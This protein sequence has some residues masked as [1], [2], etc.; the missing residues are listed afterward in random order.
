[1]VIVGVDCSYTGLG[2]VAVPGDWG[3]D[4]RRV[5]R[6]T[7]QTK[8][9][10]PLVARAGAL[11]RDAC[12]WIEWAAR[13]GGLAVYIEGGLSRGGKGDSVRTQSRLIGV[14]EHEL[15]R[16]FGVVAEHAEQAA[17]RKLLLGFEPFRDKKHAVIGVLKQ[18]TPTTWDPNEYDAFAA[19]NYGLSQQGLAFISVA[20]EAA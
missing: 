19:A 1:M 11:A 16:V 14:V 6:A 9:G 20:S 17:I 2:L 4:W 13:H 10:V 18:L 15:Y 8:P 3:L 12:R 5:K 7:L